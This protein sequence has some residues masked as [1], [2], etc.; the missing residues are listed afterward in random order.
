MMMSGL[1][2]K[3]IN[4]HKA[5]GAIDPARLESLREYED[6]Y[7]YE[8][9]NEYFENSCFYSDA[10]KALIEFQIFYTKHSHFRYPE[11][12][13][14]APR[15]QKYYEEKYQTPFFQELSNEELRKKYHPS[16]QLGK[17]LNFEDFKSVLLPG[18]N[19]NLLSTI[20]PAELGGGAHYVFYNWD[21]FEEVQ[22]SPFSN[23]F[24]RY[25]ETLPFHSRRNSYDKMEEAKIAVVNALLESACSTVDTTLRGLYF[26]SANFSSEIFTRDWYLNRPKVVPKVRNLREL[27]ELEA[28]MNSKKFQDDL[29]SCLKEFER[30]S[31]KLVEIITTG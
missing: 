26:D 7:N 30:N 4:F 15:I 2:F 18:L 8:L 28:L 29:E 23:S 31:M 1:Y 9:N 16:F 17:Y 5:E 10:D 21:F 19:L 22:V 13:K 27:G 14:D 6:E 24:L 20:N 12:Y 11:F 3:I 25:I